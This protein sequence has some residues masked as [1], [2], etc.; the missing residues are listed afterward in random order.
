[1]YYVYAIQSESSSKIY[2][3]HTKDPVERLKRHNLEL[4][5]KSKSF[6]KKNRGPWKLIYKE[7]YLTRKEAIKREKKLKTYQGRK[8]IRFGIEG[9]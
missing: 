7:K 6:T 5:S 4:P 3:G 8:Y 2:I 9:P 1:M